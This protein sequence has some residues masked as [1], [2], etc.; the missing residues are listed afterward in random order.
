MFFC[1]PFSRAEWDIW[2]G[3]DSGGIWCFEIHALWHC[4]SLWLF[5][6]LVCAISWSCVKVQKVALE[7]ALASTHT[8][9]P[10]MQ[11]SMHYASLAPRRP[12]TSLTGRAKAS[13][14]GKK[15]R[16][17]PFLLTLPW[18]LL[19]PPIRFSERSFFS[20]C[21]RWSNLM[22]LFSCT[23]E[24]KWMWGECGFSQAA[25]SVESRVYLPLEMPNPRN[26]MAITE[27]HAGWRVG[28]T[29]SS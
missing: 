2:K 1:F 19:S 3:I 25:A 20:I 10:H 15:P 9:H 29:V 21:T 16:R 17:A 6:Y 4:F 26:N 5:V 8:L 18:P 12:M 23:L 24:V 28:D 7:E 11:Q 22:A 13:T 27:R 14:D